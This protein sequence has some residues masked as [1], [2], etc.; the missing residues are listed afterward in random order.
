MNKIHL[1]DE[2]EA[3]KPVVAE[4]S[5][6]FSASDVCEIINTLNRTSLSTKITLVS[7]AGLAAYFLK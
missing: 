7:I 4:Q 5:S 6:I 1:S 3:I 2:E